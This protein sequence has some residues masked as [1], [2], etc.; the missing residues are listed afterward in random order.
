MVGMEKSRWFQVSMFIAGTVVVVHSLVS[1]VAGDT[2]WWEVALKVYMI[3]LG[4]WAA[5][6]S[7]RTLRRTA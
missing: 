1:L 7:A 2:P 4:S 6:H 3:A 5:Q